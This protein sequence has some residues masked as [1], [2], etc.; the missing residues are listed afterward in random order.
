MAR[1]CGRRGPKRGNSLSGKLLFAF[2]FLSRPR[3]G[4]HHHLILFAV[5]FWLASLFRL[6]PGAAVRA[7]DRR[8][9][10]G[11]DDSVRRVATRARNPRPPMPRKCRLQTGGASSLTLTNF[12]GERPL[13]AWECRNYRC[14]TRHRRLHGPGE[15][16]CVID[17]AGFK[18]RIEHPDIA[19]RVADVSIAI[20][21][22]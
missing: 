7:P 13:D 9:Q 22:A 14:D 12:R 20:L 17:S 4:L 2:S 1:F 10:A 5:T 6:G 3:R 19:P 21:P 16:F 11:S 15:S 8:A 18:N